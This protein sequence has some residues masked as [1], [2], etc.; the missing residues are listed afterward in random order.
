MPLLLIRN[1]ALVN[2]RRQMV[3]SPRSLRWGSGNLLLRR[4]CRETFGAVP[5]FAVAAALADGDVIEP[6]RH[7][8]Y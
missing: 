8:G 5:A 7:V 2:P 3:V 1:A 4:G 6:R